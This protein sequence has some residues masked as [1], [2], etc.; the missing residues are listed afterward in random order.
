MRF[1]FMCA[2]IKPVWSACSLFFTFY[3]AVSARTF[4]YKKPVTIAVA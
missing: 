3:V 4:I 1:Y 2:I